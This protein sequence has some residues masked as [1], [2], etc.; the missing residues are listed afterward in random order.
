[1]KRALIAL[2][3]LLPLTAQAA[4]D[5]ARMQAATMLVDR[6]NEL[7]PFDTAMKENSVL[8][9]APLLSTLPCPEK[10]APELEKSL[11]ETLDY[12]AIKPYL[13]KAYADTFD[14]NE[15]NVIRAFYQ[16]PT[17]TRLL[18]L[19]PKMDQSLQLQTAK[20]MEAK[21]P[22]LKKMLAGYSDA[23]QCKAPATKATT[24]T[25]KTP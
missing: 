23:S 3:L 24:T 25:E 15:L 19:Q 21:L 10:A 6:M 12:K 16:T 4:D 5:F 8:M 11:R 9:L 1:M 14:F 17:G 20:L 2:A 7:D 13:V 22:E 18:K